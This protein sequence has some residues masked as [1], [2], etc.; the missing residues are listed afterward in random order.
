MI[1]IPMAGLSSRFYKAGYTQPKYMLQAHG[2]TLFDHALNSFEQYFATEPFLFIVRDIDGTV[3][4]VKQSV[5]KLGIQHSHIYVLQEP[6]RGQAETV[7]L[8]LNSVPEYQGSITIFNIDTFRP[9]FHYPKEL[10]QWD[11]YLEVFQGEGDNWSF[12]EAESPLSTKVI[13]TAEKEPISDLCSTGL[14]YF[15]DSAFF[16]ES[17]QQYIQQPVETWA[18]GE[19]YIAPLYNYLIQQNKNI[20]YHLIQRDDV[21]FCGVPD[22]YTAFLETSF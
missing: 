11:G 16:I 19:L 12:A 1:V 4:F 5:E 22:E 6:T 20:H 14:Y 9:D 3:D 7:Y 18:K 2:K 15:S 13:K 17:Y 8:G 10:K 21:I